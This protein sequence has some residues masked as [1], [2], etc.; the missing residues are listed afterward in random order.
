MRKMTW[1]PDSPGPVEVSEARVSE[2]TDGRSDAG[3]LNDERSKTVTSE[4][5][6]ERPE[7]VAAGRSSVSTVSVEEVRTGPSE[8]KADVFGAAP[9]VLMGAR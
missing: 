3:M 8:S 9:A 2:V 1:R 6:D 7:P 4:A 5:I